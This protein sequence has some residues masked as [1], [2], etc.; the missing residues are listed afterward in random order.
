[1]VIANSQSDIAG[2]TKQ[3]VVE[4]S[5]EIRC[6]ENIASTN[7][8]TNNS[9]RMPIVINPPELLESS[10]SQVQNEIK[11]PTSPVP[12]EGPVP[13][14]IASEQATILPS[15]LSHSGDTVKCKTSA[16]VK[17]KHSSFRQMLRTKIA[18]NKFLSIR[19]KDSL[20]RKKLLF[21]LN[22]D[23]SHSYKSRRP[24]RTPPPPPILVFRPRSEERRVGNERTSRWSA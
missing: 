15:H 21:N 18:S 13:F 22:S 9:D 1:E 8:P 23:P 3:N 24:T 16:K 14:L 6:S 17:A 19:L 7:E 2:E 11:V 5:L 20:S 4:S 12:S 10:V